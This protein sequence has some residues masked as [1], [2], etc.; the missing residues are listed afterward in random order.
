MQAWLESL[1]VHNHLLLVH[2][3]AAYWNCVPT[4][5]LSFGAMKTQFWNSAHKDV[6]FADG[7]FNVRHQ[8]MALSTITSPYFLVFLSTALCHRQLL[9]ANYRGTLSDLRKTGAYSTSAI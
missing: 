2:L 8:T 5:A 6:T 1:E 7:L 9:S 3:Y 4:P